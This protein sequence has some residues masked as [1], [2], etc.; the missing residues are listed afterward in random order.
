MKTQSKTQTITVFAIF[1]GYVLIAGLIERMIPLDFVAPGIKL[2]L[3]NVI[4]LILIYFYKFPKLLLF[5][6]LK[7]V[8]TALVVGSFV[9]FIYS[10]CGSLLS[11][12]V[13]WALV[14]SCGE[15]ISPIGVSIAGAVFHNIGQILTAA[16]VIGSVNMFLYLPILL[17]AGII[18]GCAV[19]VAVK[20]A[21]PYTRMLRM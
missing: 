16:I 8:L 19:G 14:K 3:S 5:V 9:S 11:F 20:C 4:V 13:M 1:L 21:L 17:I 18:M 15:K 7:C 2:G 10:V 6:L 12:I